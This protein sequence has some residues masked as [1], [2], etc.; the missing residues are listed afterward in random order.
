LFDKVREAGLL[1]LDDLGT[2]NGASRDTEKRFQIINYRY[3][4][5]MP[6]VITTNL[7]LLSY[8]DE[9]IRS[10]LSDLSFVRHITIDVPDYRERHAGPRRPGSPAT[11]P[12][13]RAEAS[14]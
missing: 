3:N 8:M 5:R 7:R 13:P 6:T 11:A 2:E 12:A 1:V 10:H 14:V 4:Y 9:R